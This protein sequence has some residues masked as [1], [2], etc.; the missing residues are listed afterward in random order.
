MLQLNS[1]EIRQFPIA[2]TRLKIRVNGP[3]AI[4]QLTMLGAVIS[5]VT[6]GGRGGQLPP[7]AAGKGAQNSLTK[8]I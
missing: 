7:G 5:G 3:L 4:I 1:T 6:E 2:V 8:N